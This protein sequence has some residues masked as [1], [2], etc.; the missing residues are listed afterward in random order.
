MRYEGLRVIAAPVTTVWRMLRSPSTLELLIPHCTRIEMQP[1][2]HEDG[3]NDFVLSFEMRPTE[4]DPRPM[5]GWLEVD[6]Q[7]PPHHLSLTITLNDGLLITHLEGTV[8]LIE[9]GPNAT[10]VHYIVEQRTPTMRGIGY[11]ADARA[12]GDRL[13][14]SVVNE[15]ERLAAHQ[16]M[17]V[18]GQHG[19]AG[20][21]ATVVLESERGSVVLLPVTEALSPSMSMLRRVQYARD[22]VSRDQRIRTIAVVTLG[23]AAAITGA[24]AFFAARRWNEYVA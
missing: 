12:Q 18:N 19:N 10:E 11:S 1:D 24:L 5:V 8:D 9:R 7:R 20:E 15:L 21:H 13:I 23:M 2:H 4:N 17:R 3:T 14:T 16:P 22:R 6:R